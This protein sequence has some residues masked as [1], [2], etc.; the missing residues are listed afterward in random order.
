[1][2]NH[3]YCMVQVYTVS[4]LLVEPVLRRLVLLI[5]EEILRIFRSLENFSHNGALHVRESLTH[6]IHYLVMLG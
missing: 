6:T 4:P 2:L 5:V 1:M 3:L